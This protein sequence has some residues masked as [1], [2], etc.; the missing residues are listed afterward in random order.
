MKVN[1]DYLSVD[2]NDRHRRLR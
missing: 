2:K 1:V